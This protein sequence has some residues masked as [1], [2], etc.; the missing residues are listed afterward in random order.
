MK[1]SAILT[2]FLCLIITIVDAQPAPTQPSF[3]PSS[4]SQIFIEKTSENIIIDGRLEE[5]TWFTGK[6]AQQFTQYFPQ[7]TI[8]ATGNTEIYFTYD[9]VNVY[10]GI[11]CY[12]NGN[13]YVTPSMKRDYNFSGSDNISILFDTFNDQTNAF[14]FGINPLGVR[15]EALISNGGRQGS[16]FAASWDNKWYGE[17]QIYEDYWT[18]EMAI[19]FK[20]IRFQEGGTRWRF[21]SYRNDTQLNEMSTWTPI[22][23]NQIIMDLNYMGEII[24][25]QPLKKPGKNISLIPY[26]AGGLTRD[27]ED[28]E[29]TKINANYNV[30]GDA[31]IAIT[32]GLNLDLTV[33][34]DFSQVEVDRQVTNLTRFEVRFPERRQFFLENA[35][36]F[37]SFGSSNTNPFFTR[38]IGIATDTITDETIQNPILY[39]ARLSGKVNKNLRVGLLN[40]QTAKQ[41]AAGLPSFNYTVA[42]AQQRVFE[43]SNISAI[44]VNK[45]AID[46]EDTS[47]IYNPYNRLAGLEYRLASS[48]NK[49]QGKAFYHHTFSPTDT[50]QNYSLGGNIQYTN[51]RI[52]ID[53][54]RRQIGKGF[55]AEV[56]F[57]PRQDFTFFS[58]EIE[59]YFYPRKGILNR[60]SLQLDYRELRQLSITDVSY[61]KKGDVTERT[62]ELSWA[63]NFRNNTR[64]RLTIRHNHILLL[65]DFDPT[66]IQSEDIFLAEGTRYDYLFLNGSY[67]S[68]QRQQF[69]WR[70]EPTIG[71]FFN[72]FRAGLR[73][74]F[75]YQIQPFG[76]I[77]L[78]Y[79]YNHIRLEAPFEST[80]LYLFGPRVEL[81]FSKKVFFTTFIQYNN[82]QEN[83]N[84]NARF[85]WRFKPVSDFFLVYTDNYLI[86]P[87]GVRNRALVAKL[88]YWLNL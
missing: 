8:L 28:I 27:F 23:R 1:Q 18:A 38:R 64:G 20:T 61:L 22:P 69:Y 12:S 13:Q 88:T 46:G 34:P 31:K 16:D 84:I 25:D 40:M 66:R 56:G 6:G 2:L 9:E 4:N 5:T 11:K 75:S 42:T 41:D 74:S 15:R 50:E 71:Q 65:D 49:W 77:S 17:S 33:N 39:G 26:L 58:P 81:T 52:R 48:D 53:L 10:V 29:Q 70:V 80:N 82:Q 45:Q 55:N 83:V 86:E 79:T 57:V 76:T 54:A 59:Y 43:R 73:G 3:S 87:W 60:H 30:G 47:S 36:L 35:D 78:D 14:L 68:D 37:S 32:S 51:R 67:N 62:T 85:Q 44:L 21:N 72:G 24:W 7:D 19:P 63:L